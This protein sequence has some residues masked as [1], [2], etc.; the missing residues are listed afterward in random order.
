MLWLR[1]GGGFYNNTPEP[2]SS[3]GSV[4]AARFAA[5]CSWCSLPEAIPHAE[6]ETFKGAMP[7]WLL[8]CI[9]IQSDGV[10]AIFLSARW[11]KFKETL[12]SFLA[13]FPD[14]AAFSRLLPCPTSLEETGVFLLPSPPPKKVPEDYPE[15]RWGEH[16]QYEA[17]QNQPTP[18]CGVSLPMP[19]VGLDSQ[20]LFRG[21]SSE[22]EGLEEH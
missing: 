6:W 22:R 4:R 9:L 7:S 10:F 19:C 14:R 11:E 13:S 21:R 15:S 3:V 18:S 17:G 5:H 16:L 12:S 20:R 2:V 8:P 1:D